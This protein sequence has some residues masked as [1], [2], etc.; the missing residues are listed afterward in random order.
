[1]STILDNI[2]KNISRKSAKDISKRLTDKYEDRNLQNVKIS[3]NKFRF[4][5]KN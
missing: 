5:E 3:L 2:L 4:L 1:M